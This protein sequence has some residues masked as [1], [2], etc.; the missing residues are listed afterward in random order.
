MSGCFT[1]SKALAP[2]LCLLVLSYLACIPRALE[3]NSG[4]CFNC[5]SISYLPRYYCSPVQKQR[6]K[7]WFLYCP[8]R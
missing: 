2:F 5:L 8:T 4:L 7:C 3:K 1:A 6:L